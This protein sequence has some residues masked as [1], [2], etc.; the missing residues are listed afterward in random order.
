MSTDFNSQLTSRRPK[1]H[2][3]EVKYYFYRSHTHK[4]RSMVPY[5][6]GRMFI[7][8]DQD[9]HKA[10]LD[11]STEAQLRTAHGNNCVGRS[12]WALDIAYYDLGNDCQWSIASRWTHSHID[13][14]LWVESV[15]PEYKE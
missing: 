8:I 10:S 9:L 3:S 2:L 6:Q 12:A 4:I 7:M 5:Q 15:W 1:A 11:T 14:W 13:C